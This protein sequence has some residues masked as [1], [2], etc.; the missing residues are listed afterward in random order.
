MHRFC[1]RVLLINMVYNVYLRG[2]LR[3]CPLKN[4]DLVSARRVGMQFVTRRVMI[5]YGF[6]VP[7]RRVTKSKVTLK[8]AQQTKHRRAVK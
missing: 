3:V 4:H 8:I 6:L 1:G 2:N 5:K 7:T